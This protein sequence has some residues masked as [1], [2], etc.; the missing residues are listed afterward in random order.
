M[1]ADKD[2]IFKNLYGH[3]G[4]GLEAHARGAAGTAPRRSW[5]RAATAS[6]TK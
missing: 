2:R 3:H 6:S 4:W 1:L 5:K